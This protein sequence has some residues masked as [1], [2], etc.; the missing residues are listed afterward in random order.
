MIVSGSGRPG[1]SLWVCP[2]EE[3]YTRFTST[4]DGSSGG[5]WLGIITFAGV[6]A[7]MNCP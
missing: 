2:R 3:Y 6:D 7:S 5:F 1:Y 4:P